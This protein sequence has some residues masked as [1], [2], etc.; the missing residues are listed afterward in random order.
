MRLCTC[1]CVQVGAWVRDWATG[2]MGVGEASYE[3]VCLG[4]CAGRRS[5]APY[6]VR[7]SRLWLCV[8]MWL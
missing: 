4:G 6:G 7:V 5:W 1:T 2:A 8:E 3:G